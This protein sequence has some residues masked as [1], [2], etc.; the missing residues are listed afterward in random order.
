LF[1]DE[2]DYYVL[3]DEEYVSDYEPEDLSWIED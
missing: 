2:E 1:M 3:E